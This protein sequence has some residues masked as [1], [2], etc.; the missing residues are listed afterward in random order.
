DEAGL[1]L[2]GVLTAVECRHRLVDAELADDSRLLRDQRLNGAVPQRLDLI[3]A[4][5]EAD[6]L[7]LAALT[8][9][10]HTGGGT[11]GGEEVRGEDADQVGVLL[12]LGADE[13]CY[14]RWVVVAVLHADVGELAVGLDRVL[15]SLGARV[16]RRDARIYTHD[17]DLAASGCNCLMASNAALPPPSLSLAIADTAYDGSFVV[18]S[19]S[20]TLIPAAAAC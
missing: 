20:T 16:G 3:R 14:G 4:G 1:H 15:E 19:T 11:L 13:L 12:Q 9:L 18:V 10:L 5:V 2:L 7:H 17:H 6:D 8:G